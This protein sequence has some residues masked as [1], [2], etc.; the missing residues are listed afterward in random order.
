MDSFVGFIHDSMPILYVL[1]VIA[2]ILKLVLVFSHKGFDILGFMLS[3]FR[4]YN[5]TERQMTSNKK[6]VN[7][8]RYNNYLNYYF[9]FFILVFIIMYLI[10]SKTMFVYQ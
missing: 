9:Y 3:F 5:Q 2:F 4:R 8:M 10:F 1:T 6:K 7:Y